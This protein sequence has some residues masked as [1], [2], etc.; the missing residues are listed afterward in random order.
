MNKLV[1][2]VIPVYNA[3]HYIVETLESVINQTYKNLEIIIVD[4]CST[5]NSI[6]IC[7]EFLELK[8]VNYQIIES[9]KNFGGP[10]GP[11][12]IG[13]ERSNGELIAFL[14]ADDIWYPSKLEVQI[15]LM[16]N[17]KRDISSTLKKDFVHFSGF[18]ELSKNPKVR[19]VTYS[20]NIRKNSVYL[21]SVIV[22]KSLVLDYRFNEDKKFIGVEDYLLWLEVLKVNN[23]LLIDEQYLYYRVLQ[24]SLSRNKAKHA[25]KVLRVLYKETGFFSLWYFATYTFISF[26]RII[27]K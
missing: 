12:N 16:L 18:E 10:A 25:M 26:K 13:I 3:S 14:D 19:E 1:S 24:N 21:S 22:K 15:N 2:V 23:I 5:D 6:C 17:K 9:E 11:R 4:D 20:K 7:K 8:S 27:F